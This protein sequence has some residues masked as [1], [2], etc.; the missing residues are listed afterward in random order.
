MLIIG[1]F[2]ACIIPLVGWAT[3]RGVASLVGLLWFSKNWLRDGRWLAKVA[4]YETVFIWVFCVFNGG[5]M[6]SFVIFGD[7]MEVVLSGALGLRPGFVPPE[8]LFV[9]ACNGSLFL[10]WFYR[11]RIILRAI[12]WS[13]F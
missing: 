5:L 4:R 7:W 2:W 8:P 12:Q 1:L 13:N 11:Y 3:S 10:L 6:T 9:L